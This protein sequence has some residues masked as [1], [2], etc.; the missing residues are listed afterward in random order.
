[1]CFQCV[2]SV[3]TLFYCIELVNSIQEWSLDSQHGLKQTIQPKLCQKTNRLIV[4]C[5]NTTQAKEESMLLLCGI[6]CHETM[7]GFTT[8]E[9][10][11]KVTARQLNLLF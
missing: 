5:P 3:T 4:G 10:G 8:Q 2:F 9:Q 7:L 1:M 6:K 11:G